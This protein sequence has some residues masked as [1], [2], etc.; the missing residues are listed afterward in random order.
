MRALQLV[1]ER[2][3]TFMCGG[4]WNLDMIEVL[5][6][7]RGHKY[8]WACG[9]WFNSKEG[10]KKEWSRDRMSVHAQEQDLELVEEPGGRLLIQRNPSKSKQR[11]GFREELP[12]RSV[13]SEGMDSVEEHGGV[14]LIRI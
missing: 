7:S 11:S 5:D 3:K 4:N 13:R 12:K 6:V 14:S 2:G 1:V 10:L 8:K 9:R